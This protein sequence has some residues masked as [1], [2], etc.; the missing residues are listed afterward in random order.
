MFAIVSALAILCFT[1]VTSPAWPAA[2]PEKPRTF[3]EAQK[4]IEHLEKTIKDL[5]SINKALNTQLENIGSIP[6]DAEYREALLGYR[7]KLME[8]NVRVYNWH[9][10]ATQSIH[11]TTIALVVTA[12]VLSVAQIVF[13]MV[14]RQGKQSS[15]KQELETLELSTTRIRLATTISGM[16]LLLITFAFFYVYI[17]QVY[18]LK[19]A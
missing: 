16:V 19:P 8:R 13:G 15:S 10:E 17:L 5:K 2:E 9:D 3:E 18:D 14:Y 12:L 1:I 4:Q 7:K 11:N 6:S